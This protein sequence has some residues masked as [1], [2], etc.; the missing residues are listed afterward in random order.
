M[1]Y[2]HINSLDKLASCENIVYSSI[3]LMLA[4]VDDVFN[5]KLFLEA[6]LSYFDH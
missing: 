1:H 6:Y 2:A 5:C 3:A 4:V